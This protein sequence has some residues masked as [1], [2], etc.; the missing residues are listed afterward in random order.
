[1]KARNHKTLTVPAVPTRR[2]DVVEILHGHSLVDPYRWLEDGTSDETRRWTEKQSART[3]TVLSN[4]PG[5]DFIERQL[6]DLLQ[7]GSVTDGQH[8]GGCFFYLRR[9]GAQN[10]ASLCVRD[11]VDGNERVLVD[12]TARG[13]EGMTAL[14]WWHPSQD[15]TLVA[16]GLSENGDE[17]STLYVIDVKTGE[18]LDLQIPRA[19]ASSV[20]WLPDNSGFYYARYPA[21][22]SVSPGEENYNRHIYFH[23]MGTNPLGDPKVFGAGR[24]PEELNSVKIDPTGRW[25]VVEADEGWVRTELHVLDRQEPDGAFR[26][27]TPPDDALHSVMEIVDGVLY[28]LTNWDAPNRQVTSFPLEAEGGAEWSTVIAEREDRVI[29]FATLTRDGI[30]NAELE[31]AVSIVRR[32][33][34]DGTSQGDLD[35]PGIGMVQSLHGSADT[36]VIVAGYTSFVHPPTSLVYTGSNRAPTELQQIDLPQG[37]DLNEFE[38]RQVW[39]PSKDGTHISM[40]IVHRRGICLDGDNPLYLTGYGG[41]NVTRGSEYLPALPLWLAHGGVYAV[42]NLRGGSE[43]GASWHRD[44]ML[45]RKQNT[46]DD[47]IA[48]AEWLIAE[49]YTSAERLGIAGGSNGGLL[50]GAAM[51]QRPELFRAVVCK[52]PLLDMIRYHLFRIARLWISEYGSADDPEQFRW[53]ISYSPYQAVE[54]GMVYPATLLT[55]G[56]NDSRVDPMHAR[57]MTARLQ[58]ATAGRDDRPILLR[59]EANAGHGQGKPLWKR[60]A[61]AADEWGFMGWQLGIEWEQ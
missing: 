6:R 8:L 33:G 27:I 40:F 3:E 24:P 9:E 43:Y 50:V 11:S 47:F 48:A 60:V 26:N 32:Y 37:F 1:M 12:P 31:N 42:P 16:F 30:V 34:R 29:E 18:E 39:Y 61:E 17:W 2:D 36:D 21:P 44:G 54:D 45:D 35:L 59:A 28:D 4:V 53:L 46:F 20:A 58:A 7:V 49:G 41:F 10:Q 5:R 13:E 51:T 52:V 14:D 25:V 19:R 23:Q 56:E 57:K 15:G 38:I 55:L 22:E